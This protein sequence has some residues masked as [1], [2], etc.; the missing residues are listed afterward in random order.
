MGHFFRT[1]DVL[2]VYLCEEVRG[3]SSPPC[4]VEGFAVT[5]YEYPVFFWRS[6][7]YLK[8]VV[9]KLGEAAWICRGCWWRTSYV[10][11]VCCG[12]WGHVCRGFVRDRLG[13]LQVEV[14]PLAFCGI[15]WVKPDSLW[16]RGN[17]TAGLAMLTASLWLQ[18]LYIDR[19]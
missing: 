16:L 1:C 15:E 13:F 2:P 9:D 11:F 6:G 19:L 12:P 5:G 17:V 18:H 10:H 4:Q 8:Y 3:N 14:F 7:H